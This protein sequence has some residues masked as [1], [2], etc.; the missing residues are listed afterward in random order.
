MAL[1]A[2]HAALSCFVHVDRGLSVVALGR[3]L[4]TC[5]PT[6]NRG[7]QQT[8]FGSLINLAASTGSAKTGVL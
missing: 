1:T 7:G 5:E 3:N 2:A 6:L 8:I 4:R